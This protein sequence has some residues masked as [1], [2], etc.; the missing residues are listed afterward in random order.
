[1]SRKL[2]SAVARWL[3]RELADAPD[4]ERALAGV[5]ACWPA[6][7]P[8]A[9]F[10]AAVLRAVGL[11]P[12]SAGWA[13]AW[14]FR[15]AF[16]LGLLL[17]VPALGHLAGLAWELGRSGQLAAFAAWA[18]VGLGEG[19]AIV[20]ATLGALFDA[21]RPLAATLRGPAVLA[22]CMATALLALAAFWRL[23]TLLMVDRSRTHA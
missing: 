9:G 23:Q 17:A 1:M 12:A 2:R 20:Q 6:L 19:T 8:S 22:F 21:G 13:P 7:A 14:V 5:Y 15:W 3:S 10:T 16:G 18:L 4:A 11:A